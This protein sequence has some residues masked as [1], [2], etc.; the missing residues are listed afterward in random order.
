M[1]ADLEKIFQVEIPQYILTINKIIKST[2]LSANGLSNVRNEARKTYNQMMTAR[3]ENRESST[4]NKR[5]KLTLT[6]VGENNAIEKV[7]IVLCRFTNDC[8]L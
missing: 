8:C 4:P 6:H 1:H 7:I 3:N 2:D 5:Q